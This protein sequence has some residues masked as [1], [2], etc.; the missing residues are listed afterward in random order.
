MTAPCGSLISRPP[1]KAVDPR[2]SCGYRSQR[3]AV[4]DGESRRSARGGVPSMT[5][6]RCGEPAVFHMQKMGIVKL[7]V[8]AETCTHCVASLVL[9]HNNIWGLRRPKSPQLDNAVGMPGAPC[10]TAEV[11][12]S[13]PSR[14]IA[15]EGSTMLRVFTR[16]TRE[17]AMMLFGTLFPRT[18]RSE[19]RESTV[20]VTAAPHPHC[21]SID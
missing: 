6:E 16:D 3:G 7:R 1:T 4:C 20:S 2:T 15:G 21:A 9:P 18:R 14:S 5:A 11:N 17:D 19:C 8:Y 13:L 10:S 12:A